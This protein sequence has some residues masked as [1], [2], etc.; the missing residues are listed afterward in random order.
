[1]EGNSNHTAHGIMLQEVERDAGTPV[2]RSTLPRSG[3]RSLK[4][5]QAVLPDCYVTVRRSPKLQV[6]KVFYL[7]G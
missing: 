4:V 6:Q 5:S 2:A 7:E 1:M 3:R